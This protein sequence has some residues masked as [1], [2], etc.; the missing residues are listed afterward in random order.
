MEDFFNRVHYG[1]VLYTQTCGT[2]ESGDQFGFI[3]TDEPRLPIYF[4]QSHVSRSNRLE[5]FDVVKFKLYQHPNYLTEAVEICF[6]NEQVY[7]KA[8][9]RL[10][11]PQ[12]HC[13]R[14]GFDG[15]LKNLCMP[16][17]ESYRFRSKIELFE[18]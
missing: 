9:K 6:E 16:P 15:H 10:T 12:Y 7:E 13:D 17:P 14:C 4:H 3:Q 18:S 8:E 2:K 1:T 11:Y 5:P